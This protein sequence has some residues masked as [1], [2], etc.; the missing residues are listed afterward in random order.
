MRIISGIY[1]GR[2]LVE[3][4]GCEVR[5]TSD[6]SRESLFNILSTRVSGCVFLDAFSGTG[7]VGIEALSRGA[8]RVDFNDVSKDSIEII[9]QNLSKIGN[10]KNVLVTCGDALAKLK[11]STNIYD[12]IFLDPPY[13][14]DLIEKA[15]F[16]SAN[17]I[18]QGGLI[19]LEDDRF[20][21]GEITGLSK[22]DLRKYGKAHF[23]FFTKGENI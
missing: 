8:I 10:P 23:T 19:I 18:K 6:M 4:K 11:N 20:F 13:G 7:A 14:A 15:L 22:C 21:N 17:A 2:R 9:K 12:I 3:F 16:L 5:P 1:K